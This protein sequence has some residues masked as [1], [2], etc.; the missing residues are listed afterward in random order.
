MSIL[1]TIAALARADCKGGDC[2]SSADDYQFVV[3]QVVPDRMGKRYGLSTC[4]GCDIDA[5]TLEFVDK[6]LVV[7]GSHGRPA[8]ALHLGVKKAL[9]MASGEAES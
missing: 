1:C 6:S 5:A 4:Y 9:A 2:I 7:V 3:W 8:S